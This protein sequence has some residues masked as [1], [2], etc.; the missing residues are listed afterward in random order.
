MNRKEELELLIPAL[1]EKLENK[2]FRLK[3][4]QDDVEE[5]S[6]TFDE[7]KLIVL[8][9]DSIMYEHYKTFKSKKL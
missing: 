3:H 6:E 2:V 5:R 1:I 8:E 4:D 7:V 9:L